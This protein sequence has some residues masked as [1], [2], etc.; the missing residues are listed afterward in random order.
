VSH[1][2]DFD[3]GEL[4]DDADRRAVRG[5]GHMVV[6]GTWRRGEHLDPG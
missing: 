3:L 5:S 6:V 2:Y 4:P 1:R